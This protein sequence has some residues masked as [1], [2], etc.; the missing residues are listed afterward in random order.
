MIG[1]GILGGRAAVRPRAMGDTYQ[2][3][4]PAECWGQTGFNDCHAKAYA[5]AQSECESNGLK[6]DLDCINPAADSITMQNCT[7]KRTA[8]PA[9][10]T[11]TT[12]AAK[13]PV[14]VS[15]SSSS[16]TTPFAPPAPMLFGMDMKTVAMVALVGVGAYV[17]LGGSS[18]KK[19]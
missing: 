15:S 19:G 12:T 18:G 10:T 3:I 8:T 7:C 14:V 13:K 1:L 16:S 9:K 2:S 4:I 11:T 5:Q 6:D 17:F